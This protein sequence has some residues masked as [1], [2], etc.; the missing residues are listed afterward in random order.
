MRAV[1]QE[2]GD[3][4]ILVIAQLVTPAWGRLLRMLP[5]EANGRDSA[6]IRSEA[7][8]KLSWRRFEAL[9]AITSTS[10]AA[11]IEGVPISEH[12]LQPT[13]AASAVYVDQALREVARRML[14]D[15]PRTEDLEERVDASNQAQ[16]AAW[17]ATAAYLSLFALSVEDATVPVGLHVRIFHYMQTVIQAFADDMASKIYITAHDS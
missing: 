6:I 5:D 1:L 10:L 14:G 2:V 9:S 12:G 11:T 13:G 8:Q 15:Q 7:M 17:K 3:A 16:V 4:P